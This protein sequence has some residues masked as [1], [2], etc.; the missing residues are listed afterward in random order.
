MRSNSPRMR[1]RGWVPADKWRS[2]APCSFINLKKASICAIGLH[3]EWIPL[4]GVKPNKLIGGSHKKL[5]QWYQFSL[6]KLG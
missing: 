2:E 1:S 4:R 5:N 6:T 3:L